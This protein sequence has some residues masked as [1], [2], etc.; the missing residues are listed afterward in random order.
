MKKISVTDIHRMKADGEK[1]PVLT[2]YSYPFARIVDSSGV[3]VIM[4]GELLNQGGGVP[5]VGETKDI[6][7]TE[8]EM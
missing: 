3:P 2:S 1:I 6:C 8:F 4:V 5:L 7:G